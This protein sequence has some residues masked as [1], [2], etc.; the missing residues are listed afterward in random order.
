MTSTAQSDAGLFEPAMRGDRYLP[1]EG[2]GAISTWRL[3]LPAEFRTFDYETITDV[4][5]H[6]R[7]TARD[8]DPLHDATVASV[9]ARL[10]DAAAHP[11]ARAFSLRHEFP[12][13]WR[14][15]KNT[16]AS[17]ATAVTVDLPAG[18]FPYFVQGRPIQIRQASVIA[19]LQ[20]GSPAVQIAIAPGQAAPTLGNPAWTGQA[21]PGPFTVA[22]NADPA[23][24]QDILV[25]L[26][27]TA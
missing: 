2:A 21:P 27:Y 17:A 10:A 25:V 26:A 3:E 18:R 14:G 11:L 22:T 7:Y 24:V 20:L 1:F 6:L 23:L 4:I 12:N 8:A 16:S 13:E 5:M 9:K 19:R 15:F